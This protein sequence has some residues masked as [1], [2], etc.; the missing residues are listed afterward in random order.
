[1][2]RISGGSC[3]RRGAC[4]GVHFVQSIPSPSSWVDILPLAG[5]E[6]DGRLLPAGEQIARS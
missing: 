5:V 1:M 3:V 2:V 4:C 6:W